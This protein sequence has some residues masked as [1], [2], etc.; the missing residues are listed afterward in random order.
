MGSRNYFGLIAL[1]PF[2]FW[3]FCGY[4]SINAISGSKTFNE[5]QIKVNKGGLSTGLQQ[6]KEVTPPISARDD[7]IRDC[8]LSGNC[9][10]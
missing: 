10:D 4:S 7:K 5:S 3:Y 8:Y 6:V 2:F 1:I 9:Q